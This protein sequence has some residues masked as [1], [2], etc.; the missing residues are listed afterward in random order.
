MSPTT[1][2]SIGS[3]TVIIECLHISSLKFL[4]RSLSELSVQFRLLYRTNKI[5][6]TNRGGGCCVTPCSAAQAADAGVDNLQRC[7]EAL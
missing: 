2:A 4:L 1:S 5:S 6:S 7:D 3:D